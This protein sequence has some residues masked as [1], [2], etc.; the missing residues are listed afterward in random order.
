MGYVL[1]FFIIFDEYGMFL[2]V[3]YLIEN[4]IE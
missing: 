2:L 1:V 3:G 4:I